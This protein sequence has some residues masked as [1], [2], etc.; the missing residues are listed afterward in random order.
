MLL[1]LFAMMLLAS[2]ANLPLL[3]ALNHG[4]GMNDVARA[5]IIIQNKHHLNPPATIAPANHPA[6][7]VSPV[8]G[9]GVTGTTDHC[10]GLLH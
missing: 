2:A 9:V 8:F 4:A 7:S 5:T 1:S 10:F 6:L 3:V